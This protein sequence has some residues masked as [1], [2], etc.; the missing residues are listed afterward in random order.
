MFPNTSFSLF[1][2]ITAD[3]MSGEMNRNVFYCAEEPECQWFQ[4]F[5]EHRLP[6][7]VKKLFVQSPP[8]RA[9]SKPRQAHTQPITQRY[10]LKLALISCCFQAPHP[11]SYGQAQTWKNRVLRLYNGFTSFLFFPVTV[12]LGGWHWLLQT[13]IVINSP[14]VSQ[15]SE[16]GDL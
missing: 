11:P 4:S 6:G 16:L 3:E 14:I 9:R 1:N 15:T 12:F 7:R 2:N 8:G 5:D 10:F 13:N